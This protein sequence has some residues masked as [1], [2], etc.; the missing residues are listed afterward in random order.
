[1]ARALFYGCVLLML[2]Q[3]SCPAQGKDPIMMQS[4][5]TAKRID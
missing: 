5:A 3:L 4:F 2:A 1:M